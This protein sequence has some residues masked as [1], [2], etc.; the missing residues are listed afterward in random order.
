MPK[1]IVFMVLAI[2]SIVMYSAVRIEA[3]KTRRKEAGNQS[4]DDTQ[5]LQNQIDALEARIK[6]LERIVTDPSE[7]LKREID[8]L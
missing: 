4:A 2:V 8:D 3:H 5:A 1:E 7:R 6:T